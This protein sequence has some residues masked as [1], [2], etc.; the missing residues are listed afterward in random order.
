LHFLIILGSCLC[1]IIRIPPS[2][3]SS[4]PINC[5][6]IDFIWLT[7]NHFAVV[8]SSPSSS[9]CHLY[10]IRSSKQDGIEHIQTFSVGLSSSNKFGTPNKKISLHQP[11][12]I[13]K[14][15]KTQRKHEDVVL[16]LL[17]AMK[18]DEDIFIL[19]IDQNELLSENKISRD[20]QGPLR[21]LPSTFISLSNSTFP[22]V[23]FT[24]DKYQLNQC[25]ILSPSLNEYY[26]FT[27]D[28]ISLPA[29]PNGHI[30]TSIIPDLF[31][32]NR[33]FI[34]DSAA[35]VYLIEI[36][37]INQIQQGLKELQSTHIQ[38]LINGENSKTK[39]EQMGLIQTDNHEQYLALITKSLT[40]RQKVSFKFIKNYHEADL[41]SVLNSTCFSPLFVSIE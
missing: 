13:I 27:I 7:S 33:Y 28:L 31:S 11:S 2:I 12:D 3:S 26:L 41:P 10:T 22:I 19:E 24:R 37:R 29:N 9:E 38:H 30:L 39:I 21:I 25:I 23:I 6:L 8:Y 15:D 36:S 20:F 17:F 35:N 4:T 14:L 1:P 5:S 32:S 18:T 40:N 16:I 34:S